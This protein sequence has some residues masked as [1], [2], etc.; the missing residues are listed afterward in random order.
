[1]REY[2]R[3]E[4]DPWINLHFSLGR[5]TY[6]APAASSTGELRATVNSFGVSGSAAAFQMYGSL[7]S[8]ETRAGA[9]RAVSMG[10]R[11]HVT[12]RVE[13]GID[14]LRSTLPNGSVIHTEVSTFRENVSQRFSL[15]QV[16][17]HGSGQTSIAFGGTFLSNFLTAS[18]EYQ[19]VYLPFGPAAQSQFRQILVLNL[20]LQLPHAIQ[21]NGGTNVTSLGHARYTAYATTFAY[22]GLSPE[23]GRVAAG[24][25]LHDNI[26]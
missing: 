24:A 8:S 18:A 20:H 7:F 4:M 2:I 22:P 1:M 10:V 26:V 16:I 23:I 9:A 14:Y 19:T 15:S 11:R 25:A 12:E 17:T 6:L 13:A 3:L 21:L 5:Q